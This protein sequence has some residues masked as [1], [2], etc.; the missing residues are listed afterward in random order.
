MALDE[1]QENDTVISD[2]GVTFI[3]EKD[4]LEKVKPIC[5]DFAESSDGAGF[6][7]TSSLPESCGSCC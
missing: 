3:I 7:L 6:K 1:S 4:L 5:I 2:K